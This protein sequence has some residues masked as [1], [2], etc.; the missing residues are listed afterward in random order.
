MSITFTPD[1]KKDPSIKFSPLTPNQSALVLGHSNNVVMQ[2]IKDPF[3]PFPVQGAQSMTPSN[4]LSTVGAV[5]GGLLG[6]AGGTALG[7]PTIVGAPIGA[8]AGGVAGAGVGGAAGEALGEAIENKMGMRQDGVD[9][10]QVAK[11]GGINAALDAVGGPLLSGAGKVIGKVASPLISFV[12]KGIAKV[13][14]LF[15]GNIATPIKTAEQETAR[16]TEALTPKLT[17]TKVEKAGLQGKLTEVN[18]FNPNARVGLNVEKDPFV[19][20]A[21][22]KVSNVANTLAIKPTDIVSTGVGS[23]AKNSNNLFD[24]ISQ[25]AQ[26]LIAPMVREHPVPF[27][28]EDLIK[29]FDQVQPKAQLDNP[30]AI[31][32]YNKIRERLQSVI[33]NS[34]KRTNRTG[35]MDDFN[36]IWNAR[37]EMDNIIQEELGTKTFD[38]P[39]YKGVKAAAQDFRDSFRQFLSDSYR[40]SGQMEQLTK[41]KETVAQAE[42]QFGRKLNAE[43]LQGLKEN[44]GVSSSPEMEA[45]ANQWD[46]HMSNLSGLYD[47]LSITANKA[48]A[49]N[50]KNWYQLFAK[51]HPVATKVVGG[52]AGAAGLG[53]A[54]HEGQNL[55]G[56]D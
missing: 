13:G 47:A 23:G 32:T 50:G 44:F 40:Y 49:E 46:S 36:D 33:A 56:G 28:F 48:R 24:T 14:D 52:A 5:G 11:T 29:T 26:K 4:V 9:L 54:F 19:T 55:V 12:G 18:P 45:L 1:P 31:G 6:A 30:E 39:A 34:I 43:E 22:E 51:E 7:A 15:G 10:G 42:H 27:N 16:V 53:A 3:N 35:S 20:N 8:Y 38:S 41:F 37:K 17:P 21:A 25:Y 2:S